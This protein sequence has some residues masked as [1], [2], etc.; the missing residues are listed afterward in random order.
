VIQSGERCI[1]DGIE[2]DGD[3]RIGSAPLEWIQSG[4]VIQL[5]VTVPPDD[6]LRV[7]HSI[8]THSPSCDLPKTGRGGS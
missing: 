7:Y 2:V 1:L 3:T 8:V 4:T 6:V 5:V